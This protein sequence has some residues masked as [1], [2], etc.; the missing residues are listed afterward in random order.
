ML[1]WYLSYR[2]K[3]EIKLLLIFKVSGTP[4]PGRSDSFWLEL[5]RCMSSNCRPCLWASRVRILSHHTEPVEHVQKEV[6]LYSCCQACLNIFFY[7]LLI[8]FSAPVMEGWCSYVNTEKLA[9]LKTT[10]VCSWVWRHEGKRA[11][12]KAWLH[13]VTYTR[14]SYVFDVQQSAKCKKNPQ[15]QQTWRPCQ[16]L[17]K[18]KCEFTH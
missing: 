6:C 17:K 5:C 18:L 11:Q 14:K 3:F 12:P 8:L 9:P 15:R 10:Y 7:L 1:Y 16:N 4:C 2:I 13:T